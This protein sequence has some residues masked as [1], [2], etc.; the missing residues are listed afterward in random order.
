[1]TTNHTQPGSDSAQTWVLALTSIAALMVALDALVVTTA[2]STIRLH[3]HASIGQLEWTVNAYGLS[4]AV[5]L[6]TG[7]ALGDRFGRRRVFTAGLG[8]F[9]AASAACALAPDV[10]SLIVARAVQGAGAAMVMPVALTQLSAAFPP[11]R[12]AWAL[13]IF[14]SVTGLAVLGGPVV[15]GAITQGISWQ[16]I[17]WLN[18]P[19]GLLAIPLILRRIDESF[20]PRTRLDV[21]GV[22]LETG[23]ALGIVWGLV[24]GNSAGWGS[25]EVIAALAL[26]VLFAAAFIA[27]EMRASEPM[28]PMHLF[29][30]RDFSSG[31]AAIFFLT[32]SLVGAVFFMAQFLQTAQGDGPLDAG[33]RLLP[34]T[35]TLFLI[36]PIA[37]ALINRVGERP[38]ILGGLLLEA[39]GMAWLALIAAPHL[40][41]V[42]MVVPLIL[43]GA[44][45]SMAIPAT[46]SAVIKSVSPEHIGKASGTFSTMRQ[47]GGAFGVAILV[48]VF[49]GTGS[50]A[51]AQAFTNGFAPAL[52][53]S[54]ALSLSGTIAVLA[55][56]SRKSKATQLARRQPRAS[57]STPK[58]PA[59][60]P[61]PIHNQ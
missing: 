5:L 18:V 29:R 12:R 13:G 33:L 4:F 27:W 41:Y 59:A 45:V 34:L 51:S 3:L 22:V 50:Y 32:A 46:Q 2:L 42:E 35:T 11:E 23:A 53:I 30:S 9:T 60:A 26:G 54:A 7:S 1:M 43:A 24:R 48:A 39:V 15:G 38:L 57:H 17:F 49:A 40:P 61:V 55:L 44:G 36:A 56:T 47:L 31:N 52:G 20:G 21:G 10:G 8:L 6:M 28:L 37:G 25:V 16:W 58:R 14:S 19:I